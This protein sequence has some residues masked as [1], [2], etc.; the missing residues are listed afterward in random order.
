MSEHG[1][2]LSLRR[3]FDQSFA[4]APRQEPAGAFEDLLAVQVGGAPHA[5]R[6]AEIAAVHSDRRVVPVPSSAPELVGIAGFRNILAPVY[7]LCA[8]LGYPIG[9][10][11]RWLVLARGP[12][13]IAFAFDSFERHLR[14]PVDRLHDSAD[15]G[16]A[17][18]YLRGAVE[19]DLVR[20][21]IH[22]AALLEA[23]ARRVPSQIKE[24]IDV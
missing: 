24:M 21:I 8:L 12:Q 14:V 11:S 5:F 1:T 4:E 13:P 22:F 9:A 19:A 6:L 15:D 17:Q 16:G 2:A 10:A 7:D 18:P 23:I 20:P 3:A